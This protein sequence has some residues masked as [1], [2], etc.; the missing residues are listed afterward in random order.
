MRDNADS[1]SASSHFVQNYQK[2]GQSPVWDGPINARHV[3][4]KWVYLEPERW[5]VIQREP[6]V[7]H[8]SLSDEKCWYFNI[9]N[10]MYNNNI[11]KSYWYISNDLQSKLFIGDMVW[12]QVFNL[13]L[14]MGAG[15][16]TKT[17]FG[18][19][20]VQMLNSNLGLGPSTILT[21]PEHKSLSPVKPCVY[22]YFGKKTSFIKERTTTKQTSN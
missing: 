6:F 18:Y 13:N 5:P 16:V 20:L 22:I 3:G 11:S 10:I 15:L 12:V 8:V 19:V 17:Q 21:Q 7:C 14:G 9:H 2:L 4:V 1:R